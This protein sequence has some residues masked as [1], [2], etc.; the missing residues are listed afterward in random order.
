MSRRPVRPTPEPLAVDA[1][2]V[3]AGGTVLWAVLGLALVV[4]GRDWLAE[5]D[6]TWWLWTCVAGFVLGI[7]GTWYCRRRRDR[8]GRVAAARSE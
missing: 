5:H 7:F 3:V 6:R 2:R 8:L 1:V 4:F